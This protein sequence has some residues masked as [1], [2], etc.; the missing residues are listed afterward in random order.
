[1]DYRE[2]DQEEYDSRLRTVIVDTEGLHAHVQDVGD[3][4]ATM[5]WGYTLNRNNN[6][7]IWQN[8]G[9]ELTDEQWDT[10]SRVDDE[11][12]IAGK[13]RIGLTF[14]RELNEPRLTACSEPRCRSTKARQ[15]P[16]TCHCLMNASR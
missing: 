8:S 9:I 14:T 6:V 7:E 4:R 3:G 2:L 5:G 12:T 1:M 10:L 16:P 13:T 11:P 15:L